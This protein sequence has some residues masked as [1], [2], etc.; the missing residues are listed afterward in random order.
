MLVI[1]ANAIDKDVGIY[2]YMHTNTVTLDPQDVYK[3]QVPPFAVMPPYK[4]LA[5]GNR[6]NA[7]GRKDFRQRLRAAQSL[8]AEFRLQQA[9]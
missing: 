2:Y 7:L 9:V 4:V 8:A 1:T 3:R 6:A 5:H